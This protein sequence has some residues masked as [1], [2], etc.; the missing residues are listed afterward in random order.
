MNPIES[1]EETIDIPASTA[2]ERS[3]FSWE[4]I[5]Y[6]NRENDFGTILMNIGQTGV[7]LV[8]PQ[9][10]KTSANDHDYVRSDIGARERERGDKTKIILDTLCVR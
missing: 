2:D 1:Y 4:K 6:P 5:F 7:F 8:R 9:L 3:S 10:S